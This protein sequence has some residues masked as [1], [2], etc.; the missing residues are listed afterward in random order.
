MTFFGRVELECV[1]G[2]DGNCRRFFEDL[3]ACA[4]SY[5]E[6]IN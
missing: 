5:K 1:G 6:L 4:E 2:T 3:K